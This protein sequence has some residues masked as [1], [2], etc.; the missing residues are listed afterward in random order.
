M[1]E[2]QDREHQNR[3]EAL[4]NAVRHRLREETPE[5]IVKSAEKYFQFLQGPKPA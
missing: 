5:D 2:H 1:Q 3:V 4:A